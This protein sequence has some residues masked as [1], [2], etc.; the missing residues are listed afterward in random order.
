[1]KEFTLEYFKMGIDKRNIDLYPQG[2]LYKNKSGHGYC[3]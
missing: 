2:F 3:Y 1:M